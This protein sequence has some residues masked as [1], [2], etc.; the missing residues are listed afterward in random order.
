[1]PI[2]VQLFPPS[3]GTDPDDV[4]WK[5]DILSWKPEIINGD[6]L[7]PNK[8]GWGAEPEEIFKN[9]STKIYKGII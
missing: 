1:M 8:P 5:D 9:T 2:F 7:V 4:P 6:L 3:N